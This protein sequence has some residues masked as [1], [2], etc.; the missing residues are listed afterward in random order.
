MPRTCPR[1]TGSQWR[2]DRPPLRRTR[3]R[4]ARRPARLRPSVGWAIGSGTIPVRAPRVN[5]K[6]VDEETERIP[7]RTVIWA[8]GVNATSRV[9]RRV[10]VGGAAP[11]AGAG[12]GA[13][14]RA[15]A[16]RPDRRLSRRRRP[17][18][19]PSSRSKED[20]PRRPR[21]GHDAAPTTAPSGVLPS[22][23]SPT[24]KHFHWRSSSRGR[25]R[26]A[27]RA[28]P[29]GGRRPVRHRRR[30]P[31]HEPAGPGAGALCR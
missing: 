31:L 4:L 7:T 13:V 19:R 6:R 1:S 8:A 29:A 24:G 28:V 5:D 11:A 23:G 20:G 22:R 30:R 26:R 25:R 12:G 21:R 2:D 3:S 10:A 15:P 9:A 17:N 14:G 16:E 27:R 18:D